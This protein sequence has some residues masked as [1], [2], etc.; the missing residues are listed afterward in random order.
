VTADGGMKVC[1]EVPVTTITHPQYAKVTGVADGKVVFTWAGGC[2][3]GPVLVGAMFTLETGYRGHRTGDFDPPPF[4][5]A[6]VVVPDGGE[7]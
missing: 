1:T 5:P 4:T 6:P 2:A 7:P 3:F